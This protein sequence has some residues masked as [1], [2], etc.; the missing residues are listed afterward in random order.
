[1]WMFVKY[2]M[3]G[4]VNTIVGFG[5]IIF[6]IEILDLH[7]VVANAAGFS[8][9]SVVSYVLNRSISFRS[10]VSITTGLPSFVAVVIAGYLLNLAVLL[11]SQKILRLGVYPSQVL[12]V[13][14][15]VLAVFFAS[16]WLVFRDAASDKRA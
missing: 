11:A 4:V 15:Y 16:K 6:C 13:S 2:L 12:G 14:T 7:P 10:K 9:G 8:V 5:I 1:M 3:V